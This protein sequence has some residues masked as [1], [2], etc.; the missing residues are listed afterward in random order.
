M[1]SGS[2]WYRYRYARRK[3]NGGGSGN[4][5]LIIVPSLESNLEAVPLHLED[6]EVIF[7]HQ[8][9]EFFDVF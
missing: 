9:D 3:G 6:G 1:R 2:E 4:D 5:G 8:S 7:P